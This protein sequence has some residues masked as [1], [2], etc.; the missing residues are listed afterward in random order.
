MEKETTRH[1]KSK[2]AKSSFSA[3]QKET[4]FVGKEND[5]AHATV[6]IHKDY[7]FMSLH[8]L[9]SDICCQQTITGS[10]TCV[11]KGRNMSANLS[12]FL[13]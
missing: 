5:L 3:I 6:F 9:G 7:Q 2:D 8:G 1:A 4:E 10:R 12:T 13:L 11:H